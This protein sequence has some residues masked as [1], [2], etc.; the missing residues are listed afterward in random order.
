MISKLGLTF[1]FIHISWDMQNFGM[2]GVHRKCFQ[3]KFIILNRTVSLLLQCANVGG[4]CRSCKNCGSLQLYHSDIVVTSDNKIPGVR[5]VT[6]RP[7]PLS[8]SLTARDCRQLPCAVTGHLENSV[9]PTSHEQVACWWHV[10]SW[11]FLHL[12]ILERVEHGAVW[13]KC[14]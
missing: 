4:M 9:I 10:D 11:W 13:V 1:C 3:L 2:I 6:E 8:C 5:V 7:Y 14:G 12:W